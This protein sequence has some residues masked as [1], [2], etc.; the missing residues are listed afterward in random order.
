MPLVDISPAD[1]GWGGVVATFHESA[2]GFATFGV[3]G[4]VLSFSIYQLETWILVVILCDCFFC[5]FGVLCSFFFCR[6]K[7]AVFELGEP[8]LVSLVPSLP[9]TFSIRN[10]GKF[11]CI[12]VI[13]Y[14]NGR[15]IAGT[16]RIGSAIKG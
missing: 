6:S 8:Y 13:L 15:R 4:R 14:N 3:V 16:K 10:C 9:V 11:L 5:F 7:T 12:C 2:P 1:S